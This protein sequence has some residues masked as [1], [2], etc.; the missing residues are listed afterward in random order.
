LW[1]YSLS[2]DIYFSSL[3]KMRVTELFYLYYSNSNK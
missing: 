1:F 2:A 3:F